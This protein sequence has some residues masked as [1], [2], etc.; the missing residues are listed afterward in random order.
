[1]QNY[2]FAIGG[3]AHSSEEQCIAD[4]MQNGMP[5]MRRNYPMASVISVKCYA[6][7]KEVES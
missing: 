2:C 6:W 7:E 3:P 4:L 5:T 1:M